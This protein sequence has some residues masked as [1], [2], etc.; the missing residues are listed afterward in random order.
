MT[1]ATLLLL[2]GNSADTARTIGH[3][4]EVA[5]VPRREVEQAIQAARLDGI[6]LVTGDRGVWRTESPAEARQMAE[7]LR[8]RLVNQYRTVRAL[9][10]T[11]RRMEQQHVEQGTLWAA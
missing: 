6:P 3:L 2:I 8:Y 5:G 1:T 10:A 9:R 7:R 11:A 4:A